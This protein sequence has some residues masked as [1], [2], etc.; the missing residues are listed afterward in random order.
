MVEQGT[1][2][3][4]VEHFNVVTGGK[5][6]PKAKYMQEMVRARLND[7]YTE[8]DIKD[9][10]SHKWSQW[11]GTDMERYVR[12]STLLRASKF[13]GYLSDAG[14]DVNKMKRVSE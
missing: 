1:Y 2:A 5:A 8:Q 13:D 4:I 11:R 3:R 12:F 7:G 14:R 9:V 6:S 10:I